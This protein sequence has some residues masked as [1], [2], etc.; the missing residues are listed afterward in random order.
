MNTIPDTYAKNGYHYRLVKRTDRGAIY[1]QSTVPN[2]PLNGKACAYE[3]VRVRVRTER[4][5]GAVTINAGEYLPSTNDWGRYGW[6]FPDL[7]GAEAKLAEI[8]TISPTPQT[9]EQPSPSV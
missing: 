6:T 7:E 8:S 1:S 5:F 2:L 9:K 4:Q 3:V